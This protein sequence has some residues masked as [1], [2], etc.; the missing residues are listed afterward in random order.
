MKQPDADSSAMVVPTMRQETSFVLGAALALVLS[1][2]CGDSNGNGSDAADSRVADAAVE[3]AVD[4]PTL[5]TEC[6]TGP[7]DPS[8]TSVS[9]TWAWKTVGSRVVSLGGFH[10]R[11]ISYMLATHQVTGSAVTVNATYC[12][13]VENDDPDAPVRVIIPNAWRNTHTQIQRTGTWAA[14]AN[15]KLALTLTRFNETWGA[16]LVDPETDALPTDV[17]DPR[18]VDCDSD[19]NPALSVALTG[20][21]NE[22]MF[23]VQRQHSTMVGYATSPT[24]IEG[25]YGIESE[26]TVLA[27]ASIVTLMK[28]TTAVADPVVCNSN[29]VMVKVAD[30][31]TCDT[32]RTKVDTLFQ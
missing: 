25:R 19:G 13:R 26:Q 5:T 29:F 2:G 4:A 22:T 1:G 16:N 23:V 11:A 9:G 21:F 24:R 27:P 28:T 7:A 31:E 6:T 15:G 3:T 17:S 20:M 8:V 30:S 12:D 14:D 32:L 10:T 18:L